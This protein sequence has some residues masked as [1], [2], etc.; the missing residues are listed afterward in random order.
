MNNVPGAQ[1]V[2][3][4]LGLVGDLNG[5]GVVAGADLGLLLSNWGPVT[6]DP[7]SRASD[8]NRDSTVDGADLGTMLSAWGQTAG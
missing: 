4:A 6:A 3:V 8:L 7:V 2:V 1:Y 5:D